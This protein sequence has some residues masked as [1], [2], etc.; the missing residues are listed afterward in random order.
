[1]AGRFPLLTDEHTPTAL[2]KALR[3]RGWDVVRILDD[4]SL[5][6]GCPDDVVFG[7]AATIGRVWLTRDER[8]LRLPKAWAAQGRTFTGMLVWPQRHRKRMTV[9]DVVRFLEALAEEDKPFAT[10]V[11]HVKP[12]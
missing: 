6:Q 5:G 4:T 2:I 9:G 10:G 8:A 12:V 1:V 3:D 7:H 11:R